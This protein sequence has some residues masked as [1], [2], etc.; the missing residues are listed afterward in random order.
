MNIPNALSTLNWL[1]EEPDAA[2][3]ALKPMKLDYIG[4]PPKAGK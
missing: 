2:E 4:K 3:A 1:A